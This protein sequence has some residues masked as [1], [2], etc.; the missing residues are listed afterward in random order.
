MSN[1]SKVMYKT[2]WGAFEI[3]SDVPFIFKQNGWFDRR[4]KLYEDVRKYF[5]DMGD[6]VRDKQP[7]L[8]WAEWT[9]L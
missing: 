9:A 3:P 1:N 8:T 5:S 6:R 2:D 7:I 4:Y